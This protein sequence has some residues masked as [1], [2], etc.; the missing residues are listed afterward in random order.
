MNQI[1]PLAADIASGPAFAELRAGNLGVRLATTS[2]ELDAVQ[3]L[4]YNIFYAEMGAHADAETARSKRDRDQFDAIADHLLVI[5]HDVAGDARGVVGTYRLIRQEAAARFGRF[6]S[7]DEYDIGILERFPG[8]L[9]ELGRS[10]VDPGHR[11][12][13][14]MQLLWRGI[15]AYVFHYDIE[16]MF[17]CASLSG[18][19]PD[20]LSAELSYLW[21]HHLAPP[22]IRPRAV[23][24]RYVEM[25]RMDATL[26][27]PRRILAGLPPL[28][29]G[30]LRLG[31][32]VGD[33]AVID[34]QFNTTDIAVIVKTDMVTDKYYR[35]YE[36]QVRDNSE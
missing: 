4:R 20:A 28:I 12:R 17:G 18:T 33:G 34:W 3:A 7:A 25:N 14:V 30:Y 15:A 10:C 36:R 27:D 23:A 31:G 19:N 8:R 32:F 22:A 35:H 5:D 6:Y 11:S 13:A 2:D 16:L 21:A 1:A 24:D 9:L 26:L 29:K